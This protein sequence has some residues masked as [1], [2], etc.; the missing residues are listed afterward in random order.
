MNNKAAEAFARGQ[1]DDAYWWAR[2]AIAK[3]RGFLNAYNTIGLVYHRHGDLQEAEHAL[4]YALERDPKNAH[5]MSNQ[6]QVLDDLGRVADRKTLL[7]RLAELEPNAPFSF[8][9]RGRKALRD[10]EFRTAKAMFAKEVDRAPDYGEFHFWL[11][12]AYVGLGELG[13]A[14]AQLDLAIKNSTNRS[15]RDLYSAKL[16]RITSSQSR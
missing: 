9:N 14:R 7:R 11:A 16:A 5:I 8:Y 1:I 10:G 2:A 4:G 6:A 13:P 15:D 3:D 12:V